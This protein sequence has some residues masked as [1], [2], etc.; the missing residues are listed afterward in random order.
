MGAP[1]AGVRVLAV[2]QYG[3][4]PFGTQHLADLGADV[5][6]IENRKLGGD[7]A[8][9]L[10][11]FFVDGAG[12][13]DAS[14]F[15]QS[16]NRGKRSLTLDLAHPDAKAIFAKLVASADAVANNLRGDVPAKLGLTYDDLKTHNP[17]IVCAHC[18]AYG[19]KGSR[20]DW[21]G[22]DFLMQ[23]EAGYFHMSG[24]PETPPTRMGLSVVDFMAGTY[25]A[26]GLVSAVLGARSS[27]AGQDIDVNLYDTALYNLSYLSTWTLNTDYDPARIARSAHASLVPCQL[28]R[29]GDGWVYIMCNKER[30]W[31]TLCHEIGRD[32][33][34]DDPRFAG[35]PERL[36]HRDTLT[37]ILDDALGQAST[38]HWLEQLRGKVPM[39]PI[40][41][42]RE[43]L[44]D[45]DLRERGKI[46]ETALTGGERYD[47][48]A[49]PI[50]TQALPQKTACSPMGQDTVAILREVGYSTAE[51]EAFNKEGLI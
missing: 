12:G 10:G 8:R 25:M 17:A 4:G 3:A 27:G 26:L 45:R 6:K 18:S 48:L 24:E 41:T 31:A 30:F 37:A 44:Q 42:P 47:Q 29:T 21:P 13:D 11:P 38:A 7:Y 51:I 34:M 14:L 5:I 16:V 2:E 35:F 15:F 43:A 1:L 39:A 22:Y 20:K 9:G 36:K 23:A 19:R 50:E 49:T 28:Y 33:L 46:T 32:D 40:R